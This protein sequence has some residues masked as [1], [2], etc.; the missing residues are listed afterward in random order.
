MIVVSGPLD[1]ISVNIFNRNVKH[2]GIS[3]ATDIMVFAAK[4]KENK[5]QLGECVK[6]LNGIIVD[7]IAT[8]NALISLGTKE[9]NIKRVAWGPSKTEPVQPKEKCEKMDREILF[10]RKIEEHYQPLEFIE[11]FELICREVGNLKA[12]LIENGD[13]V[14]QVKKKIE[15]M[16]LEESIKWILPK[17]EGEFNKMMR[18][19][20]MIVSNPRTDG[21]SVTMLDAMEQGIPVVTTQNAGSSEWIIDGI[22]GWTYPIGNTGKLKDKIKEVLTNISEREI[23]ISNAKRLMRAKGNWTVNQVKIVEFMKDIN[24]ELIENG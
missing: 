24:K 1:R 22:T 8:E 13:M 15:E 20:C 17:G 19:S 2:I 3:F 9:S 6:N 21:T 4:N 11:A 16:K 14:S 10:A 23:I 7:N 18:R 5:Q 12:V